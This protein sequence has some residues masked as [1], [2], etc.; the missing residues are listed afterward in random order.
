ME[1]L[2]VGLGCMKKNE[3]KIYSISRAANI[4]NN[5]FLEEN[6]PSSFVEED[7][8]ESGIVD[9]IDT[10]HYEAFNDQAL[11]NENPFYLTMDQNLENQQF[12][13]IRKNFKL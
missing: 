4:E 5:E 2:N 6:T 8:R 10:S 11:V 9:Y 1:V 12:D 13:F 7:L 3:L